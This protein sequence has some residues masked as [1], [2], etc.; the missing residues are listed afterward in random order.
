[1]KWRQRDGCGEWRWWRGQVMEGGVVTTA[2]QRRPLDYTYQKSHETYGTKVTCNFA[3]CMCQG[4][5]NNSLFDFYVYFWGIS[6]LTRQKNLRPLCWGSSPNLI[7]SQVPMEI[8][9]F[10][11][12]WGERSRERRSNERRSKEI[13]KESCYVKGERGS[14]THVFS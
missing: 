2:L 8:N 1:M 12:K 5:V 7:C 11:T 10:S 13:K 6:D 4:Y 14:H 3:T 9:F